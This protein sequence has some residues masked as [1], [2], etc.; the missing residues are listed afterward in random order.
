M[1]TQL[2]NPSFIVLKATLA[3]AVALLLDRFLG[4]PDSVSSTFVTVLCISPTVLIGLRNAWAQI[5]GSLVGGLWAT[6]ANLLSLD[7]LIGLPLAVGGAIGSSFALRIASGYPVAAFTALFMILV[8]R[9]TPIDT[10][11]V[12]FLALFI[13]LLSSFLV[14]ALVSAMLY[15]DIYTRR[16]LKV[17]KQIL[18][19][20]EAVLQGEHSKADAGFALLGVLQQQLQR[21]LFELKLRR[22][23]V[24]SLEIERMLRRTR[25]LGYLLHLVL[26][27]AYLS[28]EEKVE[29]QQVQNFLN[30]V[31]ATSALDLER[32]AQE[33]PPLPAQPPSADLKHKSIPFELL[34]DALVGVQKRIV[35]VVRELQR[36]PNLPGDSA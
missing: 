20:F 32:E 23:R 24:T 34:P 28:R 35:Y 29:L 6:G 12:R 22:D 33:A 10:F 2:S 30:W 19:S 25:H 9:G 4:N 14:N 8:S 5:I 13:A 16:L 21:T 17:E 36:S 7:P 1:E 18:A 27:L 11:Q 26:D 3:C 31:K 15:K